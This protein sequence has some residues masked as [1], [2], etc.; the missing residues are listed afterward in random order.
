MHKEKSCGAVIYR[1]AKNNIEFLAVKSKTDGHWG[2]PKG[3]V[4]GYESEQETTKREIFEETGLSVILL[5]GFR[6]SINYLLPEGTTK[7][8]VYFLAK[9][10]EKRVKI[11]L[12]E[13]ENYAWLN[14]DD[15]LN[16]LTYE[17]TKTVL[18]EAN[19]FLDNLIIMTN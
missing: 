10:S 16:K 5:N 7:E 8:V 14:F 12:D 4:E 18:G 1:I 2:F 11:Q 13:I 15:M 17:N 9:S 3:H 6:R 19:D